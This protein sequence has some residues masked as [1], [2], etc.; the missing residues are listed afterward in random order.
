MLK[1]KVEAWM[2]EKGVSQSALAT[3]LGMS[4]AAVS[5]WLHGKYAGDL[6]A[7]EE[8]LEKLLELE[9][10]RDKGGLL[11][12]EKF[13]PTTGARKYLEA[14]RLAHRDGS[15]RVC[16]G[17]AGLGKTWAGREYARQNPGTIFIEAS[18]DFSPRVLLQEILMALGRE[19]RGTNHAMR[20]E[21]C[22]VLRGSKRLL[23][24]DEAENLPYKS[25][26]ILRR[27]YDEC[28]IGILLAGMP[29]LLAN[30]KGKRG[31]FKQL[32][33]R[34]AG[35]FC[36]DKLSEDDVRLILEARLGQGQVEQKAT[37]TFH[38]QANANGRT[39]KFLLG[40]TARLCQLN[41]RTISPVIIEK[42]AS[43]LLR[44]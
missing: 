35:V 37:T 24:V 21:I 14:A 28:E 26:E 27:I 18:A 25:L 40:E 12:P 34:I 13:V 33:S 1:E 11:Q 43:L 31:D 2:K 29:R 39:L 23:I 42:A 32:Y 30:L 10:E 19:G 41:N 38:L 44:G 5:L 16:Y 20:R 17:D 6:P 22:D 8:K 36:L 15:I 7:L 4:A 9:E 3:R